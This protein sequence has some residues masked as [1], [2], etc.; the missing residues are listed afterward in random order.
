MIP[1][2]VRNLE[3]DEILLTLMSLSSQ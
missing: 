3:A 1:I 2:S